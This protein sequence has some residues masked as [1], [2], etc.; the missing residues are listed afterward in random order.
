MLSEEEKLEIYKKLTRAE[1][2]W[3]R[4]MEIVIQ[5]LYY[6]VAIAVGVIAMLLYINFEV[7]SGDGSFETKTFICA[8]NLEDVE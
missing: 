7:N 5:C 3:V 4:N 2:N 8:K 6:I 1:K